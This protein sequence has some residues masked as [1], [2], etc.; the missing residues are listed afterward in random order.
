M[1]TSGVP[2]AYRICEHWFGRLYRSD[3]FMRHLEPGDR[4]LR[5]VWA[6]LMRLLYRLPGLRLDASRAVPVAVCWNS[7]ALRRLSGV[8]ATADVRL[9]RVVHPATRRGEAFDGIP[10]A[11]ASDPLI[12]YIG[13]I[14]EH[15]GTRVAYEALAALREDHGIPARLAVAGTGDERYLAGLR[16]LAAELGIAEAVEE[17]GQLD[18]ASLAERTYPLKAVGEALRDV[19]EY[20]VLG[21][22][23]DPR[24]SR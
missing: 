5:G 16:R 2:V 20:N 13:R 19:A 23:V 15:K 11:P 10:R 17:R 7:E 9:D 4:G 18:L 21:A 22:T 8:P 6:R 1:E 14:D 24:L 3:R 12:A